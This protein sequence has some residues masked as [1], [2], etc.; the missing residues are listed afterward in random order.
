MPITS[1][2]AI[3]R[4][5]PGEFE[6]ADVVVDDPRQNELRVRMVA[7]GMCHSD[8]HMM[9]GDSVAG[10]L[11]MVCGHEGTGIVESVG[12]NTI[13]WE[14]GDAVVFTWIPSCG[15]CRW[16]TTGMTNLC[17]RGRYLL[18]GHRFDDENSYRFSL[19]DGTPG[20]A[21]VPGRII[22]RAHARLGRLGDQAAG[23]APTWRR[24]G[25]SGAASARA[26][27]A[28]CTRPRRSQG[29]S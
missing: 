2:A 1:R 26:G 18:A 4:Q 11:P 14:V 9:T 20:R 19:P 21:D 6:I 28:P 25:C 5:T 12:P 8:Y 23:K 27:A 15:K 17:D 3:V 7:A 13:G 10:H 16:C 24:S 29:T 22:L